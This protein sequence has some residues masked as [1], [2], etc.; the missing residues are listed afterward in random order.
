MIKQSYEPDAEYHMV[1]YGLYREL[2][3]PVHE[4]NINIHIHMF[5]RERVYEFDGKMWMALCQ[6][7]TLSKW[8]KFV[9]NVPSPGR[10]HEQAFIWAYV[11]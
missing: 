2:D 6:K 10:I 3:E 11:Q 7:L 1:E 4:R 5:V 9:P 8:F